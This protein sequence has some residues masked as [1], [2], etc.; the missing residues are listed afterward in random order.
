MKKFSIAL[1]FLFCV[2]QLTAPQ[3]TH[4][5]K[6]LVDDFSGSALDAADWWEVENTRRINVG[7]LELSVRGSSRGNNVVRPLLRVNSFNY[8]PPYTGIKADIAV[9]SVD[10]LSTN[11][12]SAFVR[13]AGFFYTTNP[14]PSAGDYTGEVWAAIFL[15]D[16]G[17][18]LE[19]WWELHRITDSAALHS[20]PFGSGTLNE[21]S[22]P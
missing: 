14:S 18:G 20:E 12:V 19:A 9:T 16:R 6:F 11:I 17:S 10:T 15:G 7:K 22:V 5:A 1:L 8:P 3:A 4:A 13:M 2:F 21:P